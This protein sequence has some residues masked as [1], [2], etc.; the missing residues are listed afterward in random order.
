MDGHPLLIVDDTVLHG[1]D[2]LEC[3]A[4][5]PRLS[6]VFSVDK[7]AMQI[8]SVMLSPKRLR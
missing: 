6:H 1:T 7:W 5:S 4:I 8:C 3:E 2:L